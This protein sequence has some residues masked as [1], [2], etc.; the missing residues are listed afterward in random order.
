MQCNARNMQFFIGALQAARPLWVRGSSHM[1]VVT[2]GKAG[3]AFMASLNSLSLQIE[4]K[5]NIWQASLTMINIRGANY[6]L[7]P[8]ATD[9]TSM[10]W[11]GTQPPQRYPPNPP[12]IPIEGRGRVRGGWSE[13]GRAVDGGREGTRTEDA[14]LTEEGTRTEEGKRTEGTRPGGRTPTGWGRPAGGGTP[15]SGGTPARGGTERLGGANII[16]V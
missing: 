12:V 8:C 1:T 11:P 15:A 13:S 7:S 3:F 5:E 2:I 10:P 9:C 16:V 4:L 14:T 6:A